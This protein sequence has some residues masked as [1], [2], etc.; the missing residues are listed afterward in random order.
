[1]QKPESFDV[2]LWDA[3]VIAYMCGYVTNNQDDFSLVA[4]IVHNFI[5]ERMNILNAT[6][7][8]FYLSHPHLVR[9]AW[10]SDYKANRDPSKRPKWLSEIKALLS[11]HY[12]AEM[13]SGYEADDILRIRTNE[14][15]EEYKTTI[16][17]SRDKDLKMV[18]GWHFNLFNKEFEYVNELEGFK[19]FM[20][21]VLMGDG[22]DNVP[23]I[24]GVGP[25]K[26]KKLIEKVIEDA[27]WRSERSC[28]NADY[29]GTDDDVERRTTASTTNTEWEGHLA[30][31]GEKYYVGPI[32][33][34]AILQY[35]D[36]DFEKSSSL[37][38]IF[39]VWGDIERSTSQNPVLRWMEE[40]ARS[41][42]ISRT[43]S[44]ICE[45]V[46]GEYE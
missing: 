32:L 21:Q 30:D 42:G 5:D 45:D 36:F 29:A 27:S 34:E 14:L 22:I 43:V 31:G 38:Y 20:Q 2:A 13:Y 26:S 40:Y 8:E 35:G 15:N 39:N 44:A 33:R 11:D 25:V 16:I 9:K 28:I 4:H 3:D 41:R 37:V 10:Y 19:W 12:G 1:M 24:Q 18:H 46:L 23:G 7:H 6:E 17:A